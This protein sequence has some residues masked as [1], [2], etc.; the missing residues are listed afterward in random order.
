VG[1][2]C[3]EVVFLLSGRIPVFGGLG[4]LL[5]GFIGLLS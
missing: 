2:I 5:P 4:G 1:E 3:Q